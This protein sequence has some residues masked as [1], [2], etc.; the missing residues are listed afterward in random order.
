LRR[1][2]RRLR[3]DQI[4]L[5]ELVVRGLGRDILSLAL[6]DVDQMRNTLSAILAVPRGGW[7]VADATLGYENPIARNTVTGTPTA[8]CQVDGSCH[9]G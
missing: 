5:I 1:V 9:N 7:R 2:I 8:A 3:V 6:E 4:G